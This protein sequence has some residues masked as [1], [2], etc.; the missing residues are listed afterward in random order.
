MKISWIFVTLLLV[1]VAI[2][3]VQNADV[4]TVHFLAWKITMSAALVIQLAAL[5]GGLVG[6][7]AG[8]WSK[9]KAPA[10]P[11]VVATSGHGMDPS[12]VSPN[13]VT[14]PSKSDGLAPL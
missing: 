8:F 9:R 5:L 14:S 7:T 3:S 12:R 11:T 4:M 1:F 10:P 2:F 13:P 6:L